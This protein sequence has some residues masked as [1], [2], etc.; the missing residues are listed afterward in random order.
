[1]VMEKTF[2]LFVSV[3]VILWWI[4]IWGIIEMMLKSMVG[5]SQEKT[6]IAY[7]LIIALILSIVYLYPTTIERFL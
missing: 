6:L 2:I 3:L 1:M 5:N 4:A 7:S